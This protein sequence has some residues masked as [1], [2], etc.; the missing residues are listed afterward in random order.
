M[1]VQSS[2]LQ[3]LDFFSFFSFTAAKERFVPPLAQRFLNA[4][5]IEEPDNDTR[6]NHAALTGTPTRNQAAWMIQWLS[7]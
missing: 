3:P 1:A 7:A 4:R 6:I 2:S 5:N